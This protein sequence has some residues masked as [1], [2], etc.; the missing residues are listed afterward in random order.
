MTPLC[1]LYFHNHILNISQDLLVSN[2]HIKTFPPLY[3]C[4][5]TS[6]THTNSPP[7]LRTFSC[8][9]HDQLLLPSKASPHFI[10]QS[11]LFFLCD[12]HYKHVWFITFFLLRV[13]ATQC[14][15]VRSLAQVSHFQ[16]CHR[17]S[18][19]HRSHCIYTP[20]PMTVFPLI[21]RAFLWWGNPAAVGA[22]PPPV[23][24]ID[25][26]SCIFTMFMPRQ[27]M[28]MLIIYL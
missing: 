8:L 25:V 11:V 14:C 23:Y 19:F 15:N 18:H 6:H 13:S 4:V 27:N 20:V 21:L 26:V 10:L 12:S 28:C 5:L 24:F 17:C 7:T 9:G 1:Y 22:F 2:F 16:W 3:L